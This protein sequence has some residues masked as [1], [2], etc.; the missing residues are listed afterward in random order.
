MPSTVTFLVMTSLPVTRLLVNSACL[1]SPGTIF[2]STPFTPTTVMF[3]G[4]PVSFSV[5]L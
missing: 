2:A 4:M 5:T 3:A 1:V